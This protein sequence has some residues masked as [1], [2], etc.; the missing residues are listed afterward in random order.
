MAESFQNKCTW[1]KKKSQ[2]EQQSPP[3]QSFIEIMS[4]TLAEELQEVVFR[5]RVID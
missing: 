4:E 5:N 1:A 3:V 2:N